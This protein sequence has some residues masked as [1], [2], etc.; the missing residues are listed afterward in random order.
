M[1]VTEVVSNELHDWR[2]Y[3]MHI[4]NS[5]NSH[6]QEMYVTEIHKQALVSDRNSFG[7][8]RHDNYMLFLCVRFL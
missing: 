4:I 5:N 8:Y 7:T 6:F 2:Y 3:E 1:E